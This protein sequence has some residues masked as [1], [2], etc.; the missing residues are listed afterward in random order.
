MSYA[1]LDEAV[2][3][4][5]AAILSTA[6]SRVEPFPPGWRSFSDSEVLTHAERAGFRWLVTCDKK[7]PY[8]QNLRGR[9]IA[10]LVLPSQRL[11]VLEALAVP[12]SHVLSVPVPGHFVILNDEGKSDGGPTPHIPGKKRL[13]Q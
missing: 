8:Q 1:V 6:G 11:P 4:E 3:S 10:V 7:M 2:P 5:A 12:V 9:R 13:E